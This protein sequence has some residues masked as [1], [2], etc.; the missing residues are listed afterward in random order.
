MLKEKG[1]V[2]AGFARRLCS[3]SLLQ[4]V[5]KEAFFVND[6]TTIPTIQNWHTILISHGKIIIHREELPWSMVLEALIQGI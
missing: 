2:D 5:T 3:G 6:I 4:F 1:P